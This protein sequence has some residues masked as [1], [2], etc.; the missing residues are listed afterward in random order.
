MRMLLRVDPNSCFA[1]RCISYTSL[2]AYSILIDFVINERWCSK[3]ITFMSIPSVLPLN[4][5]KP[6][7]SSGVRGAHLAET[8]K[9]WR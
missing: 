9:R 4:S 8:P 5:S 7:M 6:V 1:C 3:P 2:Y